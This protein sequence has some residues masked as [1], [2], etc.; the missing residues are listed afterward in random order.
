MIVA[1]CDVGSLSAKVAILKNGD[2]IGS[3]VV[4]CGTDP[5]ASAKAALRDALAGTGLSAEDVEYFVT[6]GYG[7]KRISF[8][9]HEESEIVCHARGAV[10]QAESVRM[11]IDIGGQDAKAIRFDEDGRVERYFYNDKCASGTGRF[12]EIIAEALEIELEDLGAL[13]RQ[14]TKDLLLSNQCVI[15]AETEILSLVSEGM[16]IPDIVKALHR[17]VARRTSAM[18]KSIGLSHDIAMSG[19]VAKNVGMFDALQEALKCDMVRLDKPQVN[20]A[21]GAALIAADIVA[22]GGN[23]PQD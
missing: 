1:G 7:R 11:L 22:S 13:S 19:G 3:A 10:A 23:R 18:A 16:E 21:Y 20:G 5:D 9:N 2:M 14:A 6:T 17:S 12:L 15:F 4:R 8:G